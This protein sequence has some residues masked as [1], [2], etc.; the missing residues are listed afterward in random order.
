M[1]T[2]ERALSELS[3]AEGTNVRVVRTADPAPGVI[4]PATP[5]ARVDPSPGRL[6]DDPGAWPG[7]HALHQSDRRDNSATME[8]RVQRTAP[9]H[10]APGQWAAP[11]SSWLAIILISS[12]LPSGSNSPPSE[13]VVGMVLPNTPRGE[14]TGSGVSSSSW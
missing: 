9:E 14:R 10:C 12:P 6:E 5:K 11:G 4:P 3:T 2:R 1:R 13:D 7:S 8:T